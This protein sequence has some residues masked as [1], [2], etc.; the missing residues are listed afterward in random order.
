MTRRIAEKGGVNLAQGFPD[1]NPPEEIVEAAVKAICDGYNQYSVTWGSPR[2][3]NAISEKVKWF[4]GIS[5]HPDKN[6]TVCCGATEA[7]MSTMLAVIDPGDEVII[8]EPYYENYGPD[9]IVSGAVPI[10]VQLKEPDFSF[11]QIE[12]EKAFSDKTKAIIINTPHNPSGK[13]FS[14]EELEFIAKLCV[15]YDV[16]VITDEIYEHIIYDG[17]S[18]ISPAVINGLEERTVTI[19][20]MSKTY[21]A[22]GWRIGWTIAPEYISNAIRKAHDFLTVGAPAP[23]Q[24]AGV[25]ALNLP[26]EYYTNLKDFYQHKRDFLIPELISAGFNPYTPKGAYYVMCGTES[27]GAT[28]SFDFSIKLIEKIGLA[29]VP[30]SSFYSTPEKDKGKIRFAFCKTEATL[31]KAIEKLQ[32]LKEISLD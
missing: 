9:A 25:T 32:S 24:E 7:M 20:G 31:I 3:R 16:L 8:F 2:L 23:L 29:T 21:S 18:H 17:K 6:I 28:N 22:T 15:K 11:D 27:F 5:A 12:L 30:G 10:Y 14:K 13:V 19:S 1:F 4:N 26:I